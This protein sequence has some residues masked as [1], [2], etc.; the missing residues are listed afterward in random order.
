[1]G[2]FIPFR[3]ATG[4]GSRIMHWFIFLAK[5]QAKLDPLAIEQCQNI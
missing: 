3:K 1:M 2:I 4:I 5:G